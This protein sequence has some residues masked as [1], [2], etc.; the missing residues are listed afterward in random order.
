[1]KIKHNWKGEQIFQ[2]P[3]PDSKIYPKHFKTTAFLDLYN[4]KIKNKPFNKVIF[5]F[6]K[7]PDCRRYAINF[8]NLSEA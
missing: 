4:K 7:K 1:M 8:I 2:A 6:D 3:V 5:I